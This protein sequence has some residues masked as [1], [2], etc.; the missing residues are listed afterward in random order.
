MKKLISGMLFVAAMGL[1]FSGSNANA[2]SL[3]GEEEC[4][5][6]VERKG[7]LIRV[8]ICNRYTDF[9][10]LLAGRDCNAQSTSS[11]SFSL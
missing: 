10:G 5:D 1:S 2:Q 7:G 11:C 9:F 8:T 4:K 6:K 3:A